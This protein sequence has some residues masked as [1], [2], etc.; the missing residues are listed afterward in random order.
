[1]SQV[2]L[3]NQLSLDQISYSKP[4]NQNNLYFGSMTYKSNPLLVQSS[5]LKFIEIQ[6]DSSKQKY[7]VGSV[8][9]HDYSF[10]D[11]LVQLDDHNLSETYKHSKEWFNK[12]LPMD[13]LETMYSRIT[14]PFDKGT[15]P[16]V[17]IKVP[18]YKQKI[19]SK[20]YNESNELMD[21]QDIQPGD[22]IVCILQ[23]KGLKFLKQKYY[24]ETCIKQIKLCQKSSLG[25]SECMI[26]EDDTPTVFD[27]EILDEEVIETQKKKLELL[28]QIEESES[29]IKIEQEHLQQLKTL[30]KNL[31]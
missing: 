9:S 2:T 22:T 19:Q 10:Y 4:V 8:E 30:L 20:V 31:A 28:S 26:V 27:Y 23:I 17:K 16:L 5:K 12:E 21:Y 18:F 11:S 24:C 6:E 14:E 15:V 7:I 29:K 25:K 3:Y 1:M 13:I